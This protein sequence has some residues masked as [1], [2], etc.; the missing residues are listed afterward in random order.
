MN[1]EPSAEFRVSEFGREG[2]DGVSL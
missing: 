1:H 2:G